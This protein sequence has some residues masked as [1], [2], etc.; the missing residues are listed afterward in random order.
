MLLAHWTQR[1]SENWYVPSSQLHQLFRSINDELGFPLQDYDV[2]I[3]W[4]LL[5]VP[6]GSEF[7]ASYCRPLH[8]YSP[9]PH[10]PGRRGFEAWWDGNWIIIIKQTLLITPI[11]TLWLI[12][13]H[14]FYCNMAATR[15]GQK[16][17]SN[18]SRLSSITQK[19]RAK[20]TKEECKRK[21]QKCGGG[22]SKATENGIIVVIIITR[23]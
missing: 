22:E 23:N 13:F 10:Q 7:D 8:S 15:T 2:E 6:S 18:R 19:R 20:W 5:D 1:E 12:W 16:K 4:C 3:F 11:K 14:G 21:G 9:A 17:M